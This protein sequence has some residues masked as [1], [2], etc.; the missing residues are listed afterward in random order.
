MATLRT[1][2]LPWI[3]LASSSR[4]AGAPKAVGGG[5]E[6]LYVPRV[7]RAGPCRLAR[8]LVAGRACRGG[9]VR[10]IRDRC[11]RAGIVSRARQYGLDTGPSVR[12]LRD[13]PLF[14]EWFS[15]VSLVTR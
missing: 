9:G 14:L 13:G 12:T 4:K 15:I 7:R 11:L 8:L 6:G 2:P 3:P 5:S 10:G 1:P